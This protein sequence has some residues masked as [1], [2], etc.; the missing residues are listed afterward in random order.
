M[1][2]QTVPFVLF[3]MLVGG[4]VYRNLPASY[5]GKPFKDATHSGGP[6]VIPGRLQAALYD[7]G[8][9][10][11]AYHDVD[12]INHGSGELNYKPEH[13]EEGV[14]PAICHFRENEGVDISYVKKMADLNHPNVVAP[15]WQQ[16][17]IGWTDDGEWV[18]YTVDVKQAGT[19][20]IIAMYSYTA[21]T[22]H[23]SLNDQ[24]AAE[25]KLP[26]DPTTQF[27]MKEY[28]DWQVWHFWNKAEC[29]EINFP[30]AGVQLLTLHY[31]HGN[32]LAYFDF[33]PARK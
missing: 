17:Y 12:A 21:Q 27:S 8:G 31:K 19:Y 7:M 14:S 1:K 13:C 30:E 25:C 22:I 2:T 9:E 4:G 32:N 28:P 16:L 29:G 3:V 5:Q 33:E 18:N 6:Q 23:F 26:L 24:P 15:E 11:I 20:K 10:G